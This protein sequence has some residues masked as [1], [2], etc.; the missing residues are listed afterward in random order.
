MKVDLPLYGFGAFKVVAGVLIVASFVIF[1]DIMLIATPLIAIAVGKAHSLGAWA[2]MWRANKLN[3]KYVGCLLVFLL[4]FT[5]LG[6]YVW[7]LKELTFFTSVL[8]AFHF[9]FDEFDLQEEKREASKLIAPI[10]FWVIVTLY[11]LQY[12]GIV[13]MAFETYAILML[14]SVMAEIIFVKEITWHTVNMKVLQ[15]FLLYFIYF[16]ISGFYFITT[17]LMWHYLFWFIFPVYKVHKYKREDRDGLILML[18]II[19]ITSTF[20]AY[21]QGSNSTDYRDITWRYF[22]IITIVH[23]LGTAPFAYLFFLPKSKWKQ[24]EK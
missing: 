21:K 14:L 24:V 15:G 10:S 16:N 20:F 22:N 4:L 5:Y 13:N 12:G 11:M 9:M 8:F 7:D 3:Y 19:V 17:I 2:A 23:I 6:I 18:V 1:R